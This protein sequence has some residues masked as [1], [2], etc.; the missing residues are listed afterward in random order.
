MSLTVFVGVLARRRW[1]RGRRDPE[2]RARVWKAPGELNE[3]LHVVEPAFRGLGLALAQHLAVA[4]VI[5][6]QRKQVRD[7]RGHLAAD[8]AER[9]REEQPG[10]AGLGRQLCGVE[11]LQKRDAA[12]C[13]LLFQHRHGLR[14]EAP[15]RR[16]D[17]ATETLVGLPIVGGDDQ[18]QKRQSILDFRAMVEAHV[19]DDGVGHAAAHQGLFKQAAERVAAVEDRKLAPVLTIGVMPNDLAGEL[20][21]PHSRRW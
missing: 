7:R 11:R 19:T 4:G 20:R 14:P 21:R 6:G 12:P 1:T 10:R 5:Q 2:V 17:D 8:I 13:R 9:V 3:F 16:V 15:R 18:A